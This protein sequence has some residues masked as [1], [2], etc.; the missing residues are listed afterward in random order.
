MRACVATGIQ[1]TKHALSSS[2]E[3]GLF[4]V[5]L[6]TITKHAALPRAIMREKV[7]DHRNAMHLNILLCTLTL[8][9]RYT[10]DMIGSC[11]TATWLGQLG[12]VHTG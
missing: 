8:V 12:F 2:C 1:R 5:G 6:Y 3:L 4:W 10:K 9:K 11:F 7:S